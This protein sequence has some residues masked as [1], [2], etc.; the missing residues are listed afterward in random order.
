MVGFVKDEIQLLGNI[1]ERFSRHVSLFLELTKADIP[2]AVLKIAEELLKRIQART[3]VKT[4]R[5][6]N[7]FHI[8]PPNSPSDPFGQYRDNRG[9]FYWGKTENST[10]PNQAFVDSNVQYILA[11]EAGHS[12]QAPAGMIGVSVLEML[13]KLEKELDVILGKNWKKALDAAV[14]GFRQGR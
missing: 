9:R 8:I 12:K 10:G 5:A 2:K 7:S 6:K 14:P 4:G 13:G 3:P 11:L 1:Q